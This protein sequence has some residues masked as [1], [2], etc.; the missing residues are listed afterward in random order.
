MSSIHRIGTKVYPDDPERLFVHQMGDGFAVVSEYGETSLERPIAIA[1]AL[2]RHVATTGI[3]AA[4]A[5]A[6]GD[7]S[8]ITGC[9]PRE[10]TA[11]SDGRTVRLGGG[12]MTL[13]PVM[14]TAFVRAYGINNSAPPGPFLT[15]SKLHRERSPDHLTFRET[16]SRTGEPLLSIDWV[17]P[18][19]P[20]LSDIQTNAGIG[21]PSQD[22]LVRKIKD[23]C[24]LY[25][26]IGDRWGRHLEDLLDIEM[27]SLGDPSA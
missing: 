24:S 11:G 12:L 9:Y 27:K 15:M 10:V 20:L 6:E 26:S 17:H 22:E 18:E 16:A 14:G 7:H 2:L 21:A 4:A 25:T 23:Y 5:I 13:S 8:D 19:W 1:I 3:F